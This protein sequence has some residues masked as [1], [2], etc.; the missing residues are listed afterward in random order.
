MS[1]GNTYDPEVLGERRVPTSLGQRE[2][3]PPPLFLSAPAANDDR[4]KGDHHVCVGVLQVKT[5]SCEEPLSP[6][7]SSSPAQVLLRKLTR[8]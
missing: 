7:P 5:E 1:K 4:A 6:E 3:G 2:G 8:K